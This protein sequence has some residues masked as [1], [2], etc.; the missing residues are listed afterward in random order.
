LAGCFIIILAIAIYLFG[1]NAGKIRRNI[2]LGKDV[3]GAIARRA[4]EGYG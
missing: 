4:L 1:K 2:L 3:T